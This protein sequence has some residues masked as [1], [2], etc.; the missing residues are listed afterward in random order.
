MLMP[1]YLGVFLHF[2]LYILMPGPKEVVIVSIL[3]HVPLSL[4]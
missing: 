4:P 1:K 3:C 2:S